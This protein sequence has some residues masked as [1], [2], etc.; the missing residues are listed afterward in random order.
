MKQI[1]TSKLAYKTEA[2]FAYSELGF[3]VLGQ[4]IKKV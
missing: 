2:Q 1:M 3:V 4:M